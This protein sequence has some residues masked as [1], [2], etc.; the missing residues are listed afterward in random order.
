MAYD[1]DYQPDWDR[2]SMRRDRRDR[3]AGGGRSDWRGRDEWT[4]DDLGYDEPRYGTAPGYGYPGSGSGSSYSGYGGRGAGSSNQRYRGR[5]S[6]YDLDRQRH[7]DRGMWDRATD[8]MASWF[9]DEDAERRRRQDEHRGKGPKGY[10]RSDDRINEDVHDRLTDHPY[11]DASDI[12]VSVKDG[13]VTLSGIVP[14]RADKR[15][16]EDTADSVS[17]VNNVQNNIRVRTQDMGSD[18]AKT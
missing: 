12:S 3:Y 15:V 8:E 5:S 11:L 1:Y 9:G 16:A 7:Q 13:E 10:R 2:N 14:N 17:G 6:D 4:T 18:Q